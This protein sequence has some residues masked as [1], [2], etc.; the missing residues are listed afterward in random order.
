MATHIEDFFLM[1]QRTIQVKIIQCLQ[2]TNPKSDGK[3]KH[4]W[5]HNCKF[6]LKI[7]SK[8]YRET[9]NGRVVQEKEEEG[10]P[11]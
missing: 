2:K 7:S 11:N 9:E 6:L 1:K 3:K 10:R 5:C 8:T 4:D